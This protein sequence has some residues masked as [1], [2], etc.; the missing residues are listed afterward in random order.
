MG[1]NKWHAYVVHL[2]MCL[3]EEDYIG[4]IGLKT[5]RSLRGCKSRNYITIFGVL[6]KLLM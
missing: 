5:T 6:Q 2:H 1:L 4:I 3:L